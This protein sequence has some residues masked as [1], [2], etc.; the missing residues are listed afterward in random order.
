MVVIAAVIGLLIGFALAW[1]VAAARR[2]P[3]VTRSYRMGTQEA[4]RVDQVELEAE[5]SRAAAKLEEERQRAYNEGREL[6]R[7]EAM[8][9]L[10]V[11]VTPFYKKGH[12]WNPL[13][14]AAYEYGYRYQVFSEGRPC[15]QESEIVLGRVPERELDPQHLEGRIR[16]ELDQMLHDGNG[17][18]EYFPLVHDEPAEMGMRRS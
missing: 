13:K 7:K 15:F 9:H 6:G 14:K 16:G 17:M 12:D 1:I 18:V 8:S 11:H 10:K 3:M 2:K 4:K 5:R